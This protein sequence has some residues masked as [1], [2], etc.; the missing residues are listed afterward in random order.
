ME[1][2]YFALIFFAHLGMP[3][4]LLLLQLFLVLRLKCTL[5]KS[6]FITFYLLMDLIIFFLADQDSIL[7]LFNEDISPVSV[8][9]EYAMAAKVGKIVKNS[10]LCEVRYSCP[11]STVEMQKLFS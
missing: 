4:S 9:F 1:I 11:L 5:S 3:Y 7:T 10:N 6:C 8:K 2:I